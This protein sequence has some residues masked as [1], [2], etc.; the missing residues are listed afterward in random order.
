MEIMSIVSKCITFTTL[1]TASLMYLMPSSLINLLGILNVSQILLVI[2]L[3]NIDLPP[4]AQLIFDYLNQLITLNL[5]F[6]VDQVPGYTY[7]FE[8]KQNNTEAFS[9]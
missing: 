7:L 5:G 8:F 3:M 9:P 1:A 6:D 4:N 2:P